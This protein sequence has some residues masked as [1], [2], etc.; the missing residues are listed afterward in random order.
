MLVLISLSNPHNAVQT[1]WGLLNFSKR[2]RRSLQ[3]LQQL[4]TPLSEVIQSSQTLHGLCAHMI[5]PVNDVKCWEP[6][7]DKS[8]EQFSHCVIEVLDKIVR[9]N[10]FENFFELHP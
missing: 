3:P 9:E 7:H 6:F 2:M 10:T 1:T 8:C 5:S 4:A